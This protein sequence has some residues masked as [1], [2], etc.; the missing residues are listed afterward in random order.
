MIKKGNI[1]IVIMLMAFSTGMSGQVA[2]RSFTLEEVID[3]AQQQ[4]PDALLAKNRF[5]KAFWEMRTS[6]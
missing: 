1:L 5:L 6:E 3:L 4:S 2:R